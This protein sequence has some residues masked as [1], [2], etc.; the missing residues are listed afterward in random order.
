[1]LSFVEIGLE[2]ANKIIND[3][4]P[5]VGE[6]IFAKLGAT[7]LMQCMAVSSTWFHFAKNAL[8]KLIEQKGR[9]VSSSF[10]N[11]VPWQIL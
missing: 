5:H 9:L 11:F 6:Q 7:D 1:M 4:I 2:M 3:D 10:S 8:L